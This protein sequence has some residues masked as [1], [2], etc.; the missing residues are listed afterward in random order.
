M[1]NTLEDALRAVLALALARVRVAGP[2]RVESFNVAQGKVSVQPL[3]PEVLTDA[4]GNT[5][6]VTPAVLPEVP[7]LYPAGGPFS[8]VWPLAKG[9]LVTLLVA[10]RALDDFL[11]DGE[12]HPAGDPRSHDMRDAIA[13][14]GL[15]DFAH[16]P[17][18][19]S[20]DHAS[21]GLVSRPGAPGLRVYF[22]PG[23]PA[24]LSLGEPSAGYAV[25]LAEKVQ[26]ELSA[27]QAKLAALTA[28]YAAHSH[29]VATT[30][31]AAAQTGATT[32]L[33]TAA[34]TPPP[35]VG[36]VGSTTVKVKG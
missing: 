8:G 34:V 30:G 36:Q 35:P 27:L 23:P 28:A 11:V 2:G 15:H 17:A 6:S 13:L 29:P 24:L 22:Q 20:A 5:T 3:L 4:E 7:V 12:A 14:P 25:A 1:R 16:P 9:D 26:Q 21:F 19:L 32:G 18:D 31:T 10:D 33:V